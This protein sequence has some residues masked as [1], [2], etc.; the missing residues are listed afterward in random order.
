MLYF[1]FIV[2][3]PPYNGNRGTAIFSIVYLGVGLYVLLNILT[4]AVYSEFSGYLMVSNSTPNYKI[5]IYSIGKYNFV[6]K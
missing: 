6:Q 2:L 5:L 4:A 3:I 1:C